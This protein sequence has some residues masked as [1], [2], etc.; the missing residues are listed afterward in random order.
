MASV[1]RMSVTSRT[2]D[3]EQGVALE[4]DGSREIA[5]APK[6][7]PVGTTVEVTDLFYNTPVRRKF[8]KTERTEQAYIDRV[9]RSLSLSRFDVG[10]EL[11]QG[12]GRG[13][14]SLLR[15]WSNRPR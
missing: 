6:P 4:I 12:A 13:T 15:Q 11:R 9:L 3:A 1:A 8:L 14:L 5:F 2:A 10:F 7:H